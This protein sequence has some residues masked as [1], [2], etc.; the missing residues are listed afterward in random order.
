MKNPYEHNLKEQ[1]R[2]QDAVEATPKDIQRI[3]FWW[4]LDNPWMAC[5]GL[6]NAKNILTGL[7]KVKE[8][9]GW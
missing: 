4:N 9:K 7:Q 2:L 3:D 8:K 6:K 1:T 5:F